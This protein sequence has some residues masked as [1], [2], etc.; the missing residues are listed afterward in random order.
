M[1]APFA[2]PPAPFP[3]PLPSPSRP[4]RW[5]IP[6]VAGLGGLLVGGIGGAGIATVIVERVQVQRDYEIVVGLEPAVTVEQRVAIKAAVDRLESDAVEFHTKEQNFEELKQQFADQPEVL[7][8]L[9]VENVGETFIATRR[10]ANPDCRPVP[11]LKKLAGVREVSVHMPV[12]GDRL[13][14]FLACPE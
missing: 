11:E 7:Q 3:L 2:G 8:S 9:Q 6:L 5:L 14:G 4:R 1:T 13:E 12:D 10:A